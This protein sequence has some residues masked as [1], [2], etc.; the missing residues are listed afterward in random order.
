MVLNNE[1]NSAKINLA[2]IISAFLFA[3]SVAMSFV[4]TI[5]SERIIMLIILGACL[6]GYLFLHVLKLNYIY[7]SDSGDRLIIRYFNIH[8]GMRK[9]HSIEMVKHTLEK[10]ELKKSVFGLKKTLV[11]YQKTNKG[12][13]Q[14]PGVYIS[15]LPKAQCDKVEKSLMKQI[16]LNRQQKSK[17]SKGKYF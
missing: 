12:V 17:R 13:A 9:K 5:P 6:L 3:V 11:L 8:Y 10:Y 14:Y 7:Y 16:M 2:Y 4:V 1:L 15:A